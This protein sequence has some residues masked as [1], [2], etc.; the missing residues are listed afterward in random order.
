MIRVPVM[1][2]GLPIAFAMWA[3]SPAACHIAHWIRQ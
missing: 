1:V 3:I 2:T